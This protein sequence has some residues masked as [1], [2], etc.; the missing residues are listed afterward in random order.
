VTAR[1]PRYHLGGRIETL[2]E[3]K[4]RADPN[5]RILVGNIEN[6]GVDRIIVNDNSWRSIH[7]LEATDVVLDWSPRSSAAAES[8]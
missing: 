8:G 3:V 2:S 1:S 5:E 4:A 6:N 7:P